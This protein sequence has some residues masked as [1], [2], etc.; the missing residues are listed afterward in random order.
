MKCVY[1]EDELSNY[2]PISKTGKC[3][4]MP[5]FKRSMVKKEPF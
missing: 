5:I 1:F 4:T 3:V 2:V